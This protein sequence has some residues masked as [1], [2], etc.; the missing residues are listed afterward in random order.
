MSL[1]IPNIAFAP[2]HYAPVR[3]SVRRPVRQEVLPLFS[4]LDDALAQ[5]QQ[6]SRQTEQAWKPKF[7]VKETADAYHL[8]AELPGVESK[9]VSV[10][11]IDEQTISIQGRSERRTEKGTRPA[12]TAS[13]HVPAQA[14]VSSS[15]ASESTSVKSHK[16]TVE[17]DDPAAATA[18]ATSDESFELVQHAETEKAAKTDESPQEQYWYSERL[19][20]N[21]QRQFAFAERIDQD[22]VKA[23]LKNGVL[24]ITIPKATAP[25]R[26]RITIE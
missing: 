15:A 1:L 5:A 11:W 21:F 19:V 10:E 13:E 18:P 2:R 17:D 24:S 23:S 6:A 14:S 3:Q 12:L 25:E 22:R 26:R 9:D 8:D 4:L 7:D 16:A 20:G